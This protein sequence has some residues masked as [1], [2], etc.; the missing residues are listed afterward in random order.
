MDYLTTELNEILSQQ[1]GN[2]M[3]RNEDEN[4]EYT[5]TPI[6]DGNRPGTN[7]PTNDNNDNT[8]AENNPVPTESTTSYVVCDK[9][10]VEEES[11]VNIKPNTNPNN[12]MKILHKGHCCGAHYLPFE[13]KRLTKTAKIPTRG[14]TQ[15]AGWD[16]YADED[17]TIQPGKSNVVNTGISIAS[18]SG[19]YVRLAPRSG[20]ALR[21]GI[22]TGAGICDSDYRGEIK[23][24]LF[25][26][27]DDTPFEVHRGDR[28]CQ[29]I[30]MPYVVYGQLTE[31]NK[32][33]FDTDR[34]H[35]GFGSTGMK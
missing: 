27:T 9:P 15:A 23:V 11:F 1:N 35:K 8:E 17:V 5:L 25:N 28:I 10:N 30:I 21:N 6:K 19:T 26:H 4:R 29:M 16:I 14:S 3:N 22:D 7:T 31:V 33:T 32:F 20:L 2:N 13:I 34:G 18:P 24:V 12:G